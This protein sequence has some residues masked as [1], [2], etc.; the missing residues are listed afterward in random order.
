MGSP[1]AY[2]EYDW[3]GTSASRKTLTSY[4]SPGGYINNRPS[5]VQVYNAGGT[6][7]AQQSYTYDSAG[8]MK[9]A[10]YTGQNMG[11]LSRSYSY[12]SYGLLSSMTD[13][14]SAITSYPTYYSCN[15]QSAYLAT[16]NL[17]VNSL[18]TSAA[19][20]CYAGVVT[21]VTGLNGKTTHYSYNDPFSRVTS[22]TDP[23]GA[24]TNTSYTPTTSES[25]LTFNSGNR[26]RD[27]FLQLQ[28]E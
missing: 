16:T 26:R 23:S 12:G 18:T 14:N 6:L 5:T 13:F 4:A 15:G 1:D 10:A 11:T 20:D 22:V 19:W 2:D 8:N 24:I 21:S 27:G 3:G 7:V 9:T 28:C 17:P 25:T